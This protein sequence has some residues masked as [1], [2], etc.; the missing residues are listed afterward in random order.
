MKLVVAWLALLAL[1]GGVAGSCAIRHRSDVFECET[2][3][4]CD[5]GRVC[6]DGLCT[7][8]G[9]DPPDGG[10]KNDARR[11]AATPDAFVCPELCTACNPTTK[12]CTLDCTAA[13]NRC[14]QNIVCPTGWN[15]NIKCNTQG[16]C[17]SGVNCLGSASCSVECTG[18][19]ACRGVAC[20][21]G[22]CKVTCSGIGSCR[23]VDCG[24]SCACDVSCNTSALCEFV[25]CTSPLCE[26]GRGCTSSAPTCETCP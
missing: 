21:N 17:R 12:T 24:D 19:D 25:T 1:A 23:G 18:R 2:A 8:P 5:S 20:G 26:L 4:D 7:V 13:P 15:C 9:T 16:S 14:N 3:N 10:V 11:D 6:N 22:A